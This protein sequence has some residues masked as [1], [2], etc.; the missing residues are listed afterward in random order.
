MAEERERGNRAV[1]EQR[2]K[3]EWKEGRDSEFN[4]IDNVKTCVF[5]RSYTVSTGCNS[6][7]MQS[8]IVVS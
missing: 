7:S 8:M 6:F 5:E 1:R 4:E 3:G 2:G